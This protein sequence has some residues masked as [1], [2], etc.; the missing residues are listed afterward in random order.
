MKTLTEHNEERAALMQSVRQ[1][2][3]AKGVGVACP[4]CKP[5][6]EMVEMFAGTGPVQFTDGSHGERVVCPTCGYSGVKT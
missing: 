2:L 6:V 5:E 1:A 4:H 3:K